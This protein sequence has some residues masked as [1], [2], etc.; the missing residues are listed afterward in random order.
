[1]ISNEH[2]GARYTWTWRS[3]EH[4]NSKDGSGSSQIT[5]FPIFTLKALIKYNFED[6]FVPPQWIRKIAS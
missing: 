3:K 1:L 4:K 2:I 5:P 6:V